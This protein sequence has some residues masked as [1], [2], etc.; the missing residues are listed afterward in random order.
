MRLLLF[1]ILALCL[2]QC[3]YPQSSIEK[4]LNQLNK[5]SV[6]YIQPKEVQ[7]DSALVLLDTRKKEEF[8][9]SALPGAH[10][11]G[12]QQFDLE[13]FE[14]QW[15]D[16]ST[17]VVVYCSVGVRSEDIGEELMEAGYTQVRNL[18]GGIFLWKN[19]DLPVVDSL[20]QQTQRVHA[21]DKRWGKLLTKGEKVY[22]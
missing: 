20:Q 18:Y 17:P 10:W 5:G 22:E 15:P 1:G 3:G 19:Q 21:F 6:P 4:T 2:T 9:V 14:K 13:E 12:Y 11:V 16:K 8:E 7:Q